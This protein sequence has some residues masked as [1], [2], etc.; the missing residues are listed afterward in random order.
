[1][2]HEENAALEGLPLHADDL[3]GALRR[4]EAQEGTQGGKDGGL[5]EGP[6]HDKVLEEAEEDAHHLV[7]LP[8][9]VEL[10]VLDGGAE[11]VEK[12]HGDDGAGQE[13]L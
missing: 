4:L 5:V 2:R 12:A 13:A 7:E 9:V 3:E 6:G 11:P 1:V 10:G 8:R